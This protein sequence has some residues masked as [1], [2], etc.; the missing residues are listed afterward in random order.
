MLTL[1]RLAWRRRRSPQDYRRMQAYIAERSVAELKARG[2]DFASSAVL[3]LGSGAGGY[4][5]TLQREAGSFTAS[6][7]LR[8]AWV[9]A[10]A[11]PFA[12]VN[13]LKPFPFA[14]GSF[15]FIY[16]SSVI[17]HLA[18]PANLLRESWRVLK[19]GGTLYLSFPPFWSLALVGGHQFKP[20]HF[21]GERLAVRLTNAVRGRSIRNYATA[22]GSF[23]LY[24]L[25]IAQVRQ[26]LLDHGFEIRETF[27]RMSRINTA[28]L[29]GFLKDLLTWHVCYLARKPAA[30]P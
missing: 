3:E 27:T 6:D 8:P 21:L 20:F 1:A 17:E 16:C 2:I 5:P 25:T 26:L 22:F 24:P 7:F 18:D 14:T 11:I 13:V 9:D 19:P 15:D 4:A 28:R 10:S 29:P 30:A 23:G 12:Q